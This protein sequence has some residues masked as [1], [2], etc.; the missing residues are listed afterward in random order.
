MTKNVGSIDRVIRV[1]I[2]LVLLGLYFFGPQT[3]WG[4]IGIVPVLTAFVGFC[5]A[6]LPFKISTLKKK[7]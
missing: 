3:P 5:P 6:Y 1:I 4:L 7:Q 2:G